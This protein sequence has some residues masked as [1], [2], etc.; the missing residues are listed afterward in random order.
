MNPL[1]LASMYCILPSQSQT[2]HIRLLCQVML[3]NWPRRPTPPLH[4][5]THLNIHYRL[6]MIVNNVLTITAAKA[7]YV[8][9]HMMQGYLRAQGV[10][11][12]RDRLRRSLRRVDPLGSAIRWSRTVARRTYNVPTPNSLWH[13]DAHMKLVR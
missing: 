12:Q 11:V 13:F 7:C 3:C 6:N 2:D 1:W 5:L 8:E 4:A 9:M 10:C